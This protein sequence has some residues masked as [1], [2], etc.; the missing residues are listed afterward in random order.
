MISL[1]RAY[2]I[3]DND[4]YWGEDVTER[5]NVNNDLAAMLLVQRIVGAENFNIENAQGQFIYLADLKEIVNLMTE[6]DLLN[7][8]RLG[9]Q[10]DLGRL[11]ISV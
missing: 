11:I 5:Y 7:L 3:L 9:V 1:D 6:E 8:A 4:D 10:Q 2:E